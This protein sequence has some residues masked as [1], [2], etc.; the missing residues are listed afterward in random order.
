MRPRLCL[1]YCDESEAAMRLAWVAGVLH[2][3]MGSFIFFMTLHP[4]KDALD[5]EA[6]A[7]CRTAAAWQAMQG[8]ALMIAAAAT[9]AR[10]ATALIAA[11][12]AIAAAMLYFVIFTGLRPA[13]IVIAPIGGAISAV[14]WLALAFARPGR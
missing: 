13:A 1:N 5:A 11:G 9:R 14:G 7:L 10:A 3:L 12:A 6:L 8:L 2:G 4:L